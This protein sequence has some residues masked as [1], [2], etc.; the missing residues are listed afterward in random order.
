M[1]MKKT[2]DGSVLWKDIDKMLGGGI[3]VRASTIDLN[4]FRKLPS[5]G[6]PRIC[7]ESE[8]E[9]EELLGTVGDGPSKMDFIME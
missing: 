8:N 2:K 4:S 9:E 7:D 1:A 6:P 3:K 5:L